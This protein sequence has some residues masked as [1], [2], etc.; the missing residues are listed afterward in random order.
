MLQIVGELRTVR[1]AILGSFRHRLQADRFEVARNLRA[2]TPRRRRVALQHAVDDRLGRPLEREP[3]TQELVQDDSQ[4][5]LIGG[6][7]WI[8]LRPARLLG[9][10]E[11]GR[12]EDGSVVCH[13]VKRVEPGRQAEVHQVGAVVRIEHDV[14]RLDVAMNDAE[15]MGV[16]GRLG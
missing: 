9:S 4:A 16:V 10:H 1:V 8:A 6:G 3:T 5:V 13:F 12:A 11:R 7:L 2:K 15:R 14:V